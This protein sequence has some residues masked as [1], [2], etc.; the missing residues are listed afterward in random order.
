[1]D[2]HE[3]TGQAIEPA[4]RQVLADSLSRRP[5]RG[6]NLWLRGNMP[7]Q[8]A[9][10]VAIV[11]SRAALPVQLQQ[12]RDLAAWLVQAGAVVASGGAE[13]IDYAALEGALQAGGKPIAVLAAGLDC[14]HPKVNVPLFEAIV[15]AGGLLVSQFAPD[16]PA[17]QA[18]FL[19]RNILLTQAVDAV[20]AVCAGGHS[21]T[22]HCAARAEQAGLLLFATPWTPG[23]Q[24]SEGSN[25]LLAGPARAIWSQAGCRALIAG[26][27]AGDVKLPSW[28]SEARSRI[29]RRPRQSPLPG[30]E[31]IDSAGDATQCY[32]PERVTAGAARPA[33]TGCDPGLLLGL[34]AALGDAG[35]PGLTSEEL[36]CALAIERGPAAVLCLD[37]VLQ[38]W[39]ARAPGGLLTL[40]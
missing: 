4:L 25:A 16:A 6:Q 34:T 33:P 23:T 31:V 3:G 15:A 37:L 8:G 12:A 1:M 19:Q 38:G 30:V 28:Q 24:N 22:L 29:P 11:G 13:G 40:R 36:A 39:L 20:I 26:L 9:P 18:Q 5:E 35:P 32:R 27:A 21:G 10:R 14:L 7:A 17:R 2:G